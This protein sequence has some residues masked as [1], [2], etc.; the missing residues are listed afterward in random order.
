MG[1]AHPE[2]FLD[3]G[4]AACIIAT[5]SLRKTTRSF[6]ISEYPRRRFLSYGTRCD[7]DLATPENTPQNLIRAEQN[8]T[9]QK[10]FCSKSCVAFAR[11][12]FGE[13]QHRQQRG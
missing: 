8:N 4:W 1:N 12:K 9:L 7:R 3:P 11:F 2:L 10:L 5:I 13:A 6:S